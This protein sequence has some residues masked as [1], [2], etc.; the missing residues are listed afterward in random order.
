MLPLFASKLCQ[1]SI[2]NYFRG[3]HSS[4]LVS[5]VD[6]NL[7]ASGYALYTESSSQ[8]PPPPDY[9]SSPSRIPMLSKSE[10]DEL[11]KLVLSHTDDYIHIDHLAGPLPFF[12]YGPYWGY[13]FHLPENNHHDPSTKTKALLN[14][15]VDKHS[16]STLSSTTLTY[17]KAIDLY[18]ET[19]LIELK[20]LYD[21]I[22]SQLAD[23]LNEEN[24]TI[25]SVSFMGGKF[26]VPGFHVIPS[27]LAWSYPVFRI[28]T[29]E[30][31]ELFTT[32]LNHVNDSNVDLKS[33]NPDSR[34]SFTLPIA[35]PSPNSGLNFVDFR[36]VKAGD[37]KNVK[38]T[39]ENYEV[40]TMVV[41][42]GNLLHQIG[43]WDFRN[44]F[45]SFSLMFD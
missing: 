21:R 32:L 38:M 27:H 24:K 39:R 6:P 12:T 29:D 10:A 44:F 43:N 45:S 20:W 34:I 9:H 16:L 30:S 37:Y 23:F 11:A 28:H 3:L 31:F 18:R 2:T 14:D 25:K 35:L 4:L 40:G 26:A 41:H 17:N 1:T 13:H 15:S 36:N 8:Y 33:C 7:L 42:S 22:K 19:M 5:S